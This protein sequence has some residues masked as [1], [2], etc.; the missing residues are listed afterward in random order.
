ML[1][2]WFVPSPYGPFAGNNFFLPLMSAGLALPSPCWIQSDADVDRLELV[3]S[4]V[5]LV[6]RPSDSL[7]GGAARGARA[8]RSLGI[9][10]SLLAGVNARVQPMLMALDSAAMR[11][12]RA[13]WERA[14]DDALA[15]LRPG[16]RLLLTTMRDR[17]KGIQA[18]TPSLRRE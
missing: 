6:R 17:L 1:H 15:A 8:R 16:E 12:D 18:S 11:G 10:S 3:A 5:D 4:L 2:V 13:A 7:A 9:A 14:A